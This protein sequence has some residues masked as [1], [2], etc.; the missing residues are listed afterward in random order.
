MS[1]EKSVKNIFES[2]QDSLGKTAAAGVLSLSTL[3]TGCASLAGKGYEN[4]NVCLDPAKFDEKFNGRRGMFETIYI[5]PQVGF[6]MSCYMAQGFAYVAIA[7]GAL[8]ECGVRKLVQ[9]VPPP[10]NP[11]GAED[12]RPI[13]CQKLEQ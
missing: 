8:A 7:S 1:E 6:H 11:D 9:D 13:F 12:P 3:M 5:F 10:D 2:Y 4:M